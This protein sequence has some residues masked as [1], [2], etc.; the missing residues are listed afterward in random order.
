VKIAQHLKTAVGVTAAAV[1]IVP[2]LVLKI[3][4]MPFEKP[5]KL[6]PE[7]V[8]EF[9]RKCIERKA[10]DREIDY[11]ISVDIADPELNR[12]RDRVAGLYGPGWSSEETRADLRALI[13]QVEAMS[14][15]IAR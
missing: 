1:V 4:T 12:V 3:I 2:F 9:L 8:A 13:Q 5:R 7:Q 15:L 6:T 10:T 11:F 14:A